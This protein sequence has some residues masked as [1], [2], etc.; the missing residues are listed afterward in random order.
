MADQNAYTHDGVSYVAAER[1]DPST[2]GNAHVCAGCAAYLGNGKRNHLLCV[3]LPPCADIDRE[4]GRTVV[5]IQAE[6][7]K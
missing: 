5:F 1:P 2:P 4:D 7:G 6:E 3:R